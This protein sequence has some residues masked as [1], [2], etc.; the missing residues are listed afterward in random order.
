MGWPHVSGAA[1]QVMTPPSSQSAPRARMQAGAL[2]ACA[3]PSSM[4]HIPAGLCTPQSATR[5]D[6]WT[7]VSSRAHMI[8][9]PSRPQAVGMAERL[10]LGSAR[11]GAAGGR[12]RQQSTGETRMGRAWDVLS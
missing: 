11:P 4:A 9:A 8:M 1:L 5:N 2:M 6:P 3:R 12:R 7:P 10:R